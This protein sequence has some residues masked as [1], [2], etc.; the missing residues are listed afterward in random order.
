M[1]HLMLLFQLLSVQFAAAAASAVA[2]AQAPSYCP[3][4]QAVAA[5]SCCAFPCWACQQHLL[6]YLRCCCSKL[7]CSRLLLQQLSVAC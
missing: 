1:H 4:V 3:S 5:S 6:L 2:D 7:V